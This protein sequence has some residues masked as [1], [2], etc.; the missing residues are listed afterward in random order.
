MVRF[1]KTF[2]GFAHLGFLCTKPDVIFA[3]VIHDP[4]AEGDQGQGLNLKKASMKTPSRTLQVQSISHTAL[5]AGLINKIRQ[6]A[7]EPSAG[8]FEKGRM[9][10][11]LIYQ[12]MS[13][14]MALTLT[15][16]AGQV[17]QVSAASNTYY[18]S[19]TGNDSNPGSSTAPFKTFPKAVSAL[20]PG[21][22]LQVLAG[23]YSETLTLSSSGTATAPITVLGNGAIVNMQGINANGITVSGSYVRVSGFEVTGAT[24]FGIAVMSQ[25]VTIENNIV[26]DNVTKN[27]VGTCGLST[28]WGSGV[29]VR[30][31][32]QNTTIRNNTVYN[33]CGEGIAVT[34]GVTTLVE[35]N[36]VSD[37]FSV[38]IYV[39]NSP[40]VNVKSNRSYCTGTHLRN[41]NRATGIALGEES[42]SGW[43]AQLH[44]VVI[45]G[46]SITDCGTGVAAFES[47]VGGTL[48]NVT[49]A[50]NYIPSG[51]KRSISLQTLTNQ[52]VV[53]SYN[54][55]FNSIYI[56]QSAGVT[57]TGNIINGT[58]PTPTSTNP[59]LPP[60]T[61]VV[62][63]LTPTATLV[64]ASP[65]ST[66]P[67]LPTSTT[68]IP[69]AT[70][71][72]T[73]VPVSPVATNIVLPSPTATLIAV[74]PTAT[75]SA[76]TVAPPASN[77]FDDKNSAFVYS[78]GW[79]NIS[80][81]S[82]YNASYKQTSQ[83]GATVTFP[84]TGQ[85]FSIIYKGGAAFSKL[86]VYVDGQYVATLVQTLSK[87]TYQTSWD[88]PGQFAYGNHTLKL[89]FKVTSSTVYRGS[90]DAVIVR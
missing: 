2:G 11:K 32:G 57:L 65:T 82:A 53:A 84:F 29:K 75:Q 40:Y 4:C 7:G 67:P 17:A 8:S 10:Q 61:A 16:G 27:G 48:T 63:S 78:S 79:H 3:S 6:L 55:L 30:V 77:I 87:P 36:T 24:D 19:P 39:D 69:S 64:P 71:I 33:N 51:Q 14:L 76:A 74:V 60:S 38:N 81:T 5:F 70:P 90:L 47:N 43:G 28:S 58:A 35:G 37:N 85:S 54:T 50:N 26:H 89:V 21:D 88:Y 22:T 86:D 12:V 20:Q 31:G 1:T 34:R 73:L 62:P 44:D 49:I 41:G 66:N 52:N 56:Y 68:M 59:P 13:F 80:S 15:F 25:N 23:T 42:Y 18:V 83:N 9:M 46:N 72:T 45:S